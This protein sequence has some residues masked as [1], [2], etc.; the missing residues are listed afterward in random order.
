M[1]F[2]SPFSEVRRAISSYGQEREVRR[3]IEEMKAKRETSR[4]Y[5]RRIG[6]D[7]R[8]LYDAAQ[9]DEQKEGIMQDLKRQI[10]GSTKRELIPLDVEKG[11]GETF[12][13]YGFCKERGIYNL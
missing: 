11:V 7:Y 10:D 13:G 4:S 3:Y 8:Q 6:F 9:T 2:T 12:S 5:G 1:K